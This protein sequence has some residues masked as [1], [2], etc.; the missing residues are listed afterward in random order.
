M[1]FKN[2][3]LNEITLCSR[4]EG[5]EPSMV[6]ISLCFGLMVATMVWC[7]GHISG[8][9]INPAVTIGMLITRKV[10]VARA[11]FFVIVQCIGAVIGSAIL[12]G[13]TPGMSTHFL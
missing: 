8:G 9:H 13:V 4:G 5:A 7:I 6:Q 10:S 1:L 11:V 2:F 12:Y 3:K